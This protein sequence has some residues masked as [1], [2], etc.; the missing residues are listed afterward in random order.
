[1]IEHFVNGL[2]LCISVIQ[3]SYFQIKIIK[4]SLTLR[5]STHK[6]K[7]YD[8]NQNTNTNKQFINHHIKGTAINNCDTV[9]SLRS[10]PIRPKQK[11]RF[12]AALIVSACCRLHALRV[13]QA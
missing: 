6:L 13:L 9:D 1:M 10:G 7:T 5:S 2:K 4:E 12:G 8:S 3:L 11:T